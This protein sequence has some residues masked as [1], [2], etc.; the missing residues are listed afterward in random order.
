MRYLI[1][2]ANGF[3]GKSL[4][5]TSVKK[6]VKV[7][8]LGLSITNDIVCDLSND[9]PKIPSNI[10][11][12]IHAAG[13]AH[14]IPKNNEEENDFF[15][16]NT[17]GTLNL[18]TGIKQS[19]INLKQFIF[20]STVAVYGLDYGVNI[21]E[22]YNL[23]GKT[24]YA[25]SKIKAEFI[26]KKWGL[27]NNINVLILRLPLLVGN[28]PP[29]NL[30]IM[31]S[32]IKKGFYVR[33]S[34]PPAKKSMVLIEDISSF[35]FDLKSSSGTF[36]LTDGYHPNF[37][38]I[39]DI[40]CDYFKTKI[41]FKTPFFFI[42]LTAKICDFFKMHKFNLNVLKKMSTSLTFDDTKARRELD[43]SPKSVVENFLK[44]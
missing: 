2:G 34:I 9:I 21:D 19:K 17:N 7:C 29:G 16:I 5:E 26:L 8:T 33:I 3:L 22:K 18:L 14:I 13:K 39:E 6:G 4:K 43:W 25:L 30:G 42:L 10:D 23:L 32:A 40:I 38:Q 20:I 1:T 35:I 31:I 11:I 27:E 12:V 15:K 28:K 24:P 37:H 41:Y 36:N 44:N